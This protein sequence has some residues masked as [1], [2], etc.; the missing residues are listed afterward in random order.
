M[1]VR[2]RWPS[3]CGVVLAAGFTLVAVVVVAAGEAPAARA[4]D[5][6]ALVHPLAGTERGG[7]FPGAD[8]PF[9]MVQYSPNTEGALG[10]GYRYW[11][12]KTWGF[13]ATHLSGPGCAAMGDVVSLPT[14]GAVS[15]VA[16]RDQETSFSHATEQASPGY[17]GVTLDASGVRA[18]LTA[19][20][21]TGWT[22]FTYPR[23]P[24]AHV[25]VDPGANF[26]GADDVRVRIVGDRTVEGFVS[27]WG[28][29]NTCSPPGKNRYTVFFSM[30]FDRPFSAFGTGNG[31]GLRRGRRAASGPDA[32]A[33]VSFN[34]AAD[35]RPVV[36]KVG[37]SFVDLPGA[38]SN[39]ATAS[40]T[41]FDFDTVHARARSA[42]NAMLGRVTVSGESED[43]RETFYTALYHTLLHPSV[44]SDADGRYVGFDDRI[45]RV[46]RDQRHYTN[47]SMWDTYRSAHEVVD[48]VAP[49]VVG[50][51]MASLLDDER[52]GGWLPKWPYAHF[53]TNEMVGDP[54]ANV[55]ADAFLKGLLRHA[56]VGR[57]YAALM[58]NATDVP[59]PT[60]SP[61]EGRTGLEDYL[62]Q[63][64]VPYLPSGDYADSGAL[65]MEY[66]VNDCALALMAGRLKR[67][68]DWRYLMRRAK[69]Y[70]ASIDGSTGLVRPR[71]V[72]GSWMSPFSAASHVGFKEGTA[73]QYTWLAPQDV[74]GLAAVLGG[75]D[76]ALAKLDSFFA[77][78]VVVADPSSAGAE[79]HDPARYTPRNEQDLQAPYLYDYLGQPWKT[80]DMVRAAETLYTTAPNGL[81]SSDDLGAMSGWYVLSALGLYPVMGGDD[82]YAL[83]S[84]LFER[85]VINPPPGFYPGGRFVIDAPGTAGV[86]HIQ[87]VRLDG[88]PVATSDLDHAALR[89]GAHL[90]FVL[91]AAPNDGWATGTRTPASACAASPRTADV[92][93]R[94][95]P[96]AAG[97]IRT[98]LRNAGDASAA[99]IHVGLR[100]PRGWSAKPT[101]RTL[102]TLGA[103]RVVSVTWR[104]R[105]RPGQRVAPVRADASWSGPG[106][107][108]RALRTFANGTVHARR[109]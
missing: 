16:A 40:G 27:S 67:W 46:P 15:T 30:K 97:T 65:N 48:L 84:P 72:D 1:R 85:T 8:V 99:Q 107:R 88:R 28:Y 68:A 9:G 93:L 47:F 49:E 42:W 103:G 24:Q 77:Y 92:R 108:G 3:S 12:K 70:R 22:R 106:G 14:T 11:H 76:A 63:G 89:R 39:L 73:S 57:A 71:G 91:G 105:S 4:D 95:P 80:Q 32:G 82:H 59:D 98:T 75:P 17:Y 6:A 60:R 36:S 5:L 53:Y 61:F 7:V 87:G 56:D 55:I 23:T 54:A 44:F 86:H 74:S 83:T 79:W 35:P 102:A 31:S 38:R 2:R 21:R 69:R 26:R 13:A 90:V 51:M 20:T 33:Y 45:H 64:F 66:A 94:L 96:T 100:L 62:N 43:L 19:T 58:H 52:Q 34:A 41:G 101:S 81:P 37:I 104:L 50:D 29:W 109:R 25:I 78:D 10:G 18:E